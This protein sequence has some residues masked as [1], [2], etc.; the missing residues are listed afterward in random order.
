MRFRHDTLVDQSTSTNPAHSGG[1]VTRNRSRIIDLVANLSIIFPRLPFLE[2]FDAAARAGFDLADLWWPRTDFAAGLTD[3]DI[4]RAAREAGVAVTMLNFDG[5]NLA[6]GERGLAGDPL[7]A[8]EFRE[9]VPHALE[10]AGAS[11]ATSSMPWPDSPPP[12]ARPPTNSSCS[13]NSSYAATEILA[14]AG[15]TVLIEPLNLLDTPGDLLPTV[16]AA[17]ALIASIGKPNVKI[18]FDVF[19]VVR[20]G[21][22]LLDAARRAAGHIGHVQIA[23][24]PGRHEPGTGELPFDALFDTLHGVGYDG[25]IGLEYVP[26]DPEAPDFAYLSGLRETLAGSALRSPAH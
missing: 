10:L 6:A 25:D 9:N 14:A 20:A 26:T 4:V 17:L 15:A 16:D 22:Y 18:Q 24:V 13:P 8:G 3:E 5:G 23:D 19:H 7:R 11:A 12:A 2:L 1:Q 21:D